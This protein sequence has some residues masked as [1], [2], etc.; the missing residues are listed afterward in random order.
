[1][2]GC[3]NFKTQLFWSGYIDEMWEELDKL[4]NFSR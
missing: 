2:G 1:M 4:M 3:T